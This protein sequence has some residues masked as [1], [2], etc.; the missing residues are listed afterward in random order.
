MGPDQ[1]PRVGLK[2]WQVP[3]II[4]TAAAAI[5]FL[6]WHSMAISRKLVREA[7]RKAL[8]V[9]SDLRSACS[10]IEKLLREQSNRVPRLMK[11][12]PEMILR[13][14]TGLREAGRDL[15]L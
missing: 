15:G 9:T 8:S 12:N 13:R 10:F 7:D 6:T 14:L 5:C 2:L 11:S 1:G 3:G 4:A